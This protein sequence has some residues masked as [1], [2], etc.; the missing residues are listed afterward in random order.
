MQWRITIILE[1][2]HLSPNENEAKNDWLQVNSY[3]V[4]NVTHV[5]KPAIHLNE[6]AKWKQTN[7]ESR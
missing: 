4:L 7:S 6:I 3:L 5:V 1:N 2:K